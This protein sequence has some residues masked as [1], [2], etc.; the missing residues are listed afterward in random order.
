MG[1]QEVKV[2]KAASAGKMCI[3]IMAE[4]FFTHSLCRVSGGL[5]VPNKGNNEEK[6]GCTAT[7]LHRL[8]S[9]S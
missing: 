6:R 2:H 7:L 9:Q 4:T 8:D 3:T 5:S 1:F